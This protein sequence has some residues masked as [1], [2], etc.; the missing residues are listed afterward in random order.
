[1][2]QVESFGLDREDIQGGK[3]KKFKGKENQTDRVG[4]IYITEK[5]M[6]KGVKAHY[7]DRYFLC[8]S[9][10]E[11]KEICCLHSYEKN[12]PSYRIGCI[13]VIYDVATDK[14]GKV[15]LKGYE[16]LPWVF[17]EK[18][19]GTLSEENKEHPLTGCDLKLKC[20]NAEYQ[21]FEVHSC[22]ESIW[23]SN[24]KLKEKILEQASTLF[25]ELPRSLSSDLSITEIKELLGVDAAGSED[26][27]ADIDLGA[28]ADVA[29]E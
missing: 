29:M 19:Y 3:F 14:S 15:S 7:K 8:K 22:K 6:F 2:A 4:I 18:M 5:E 9:T 16:L 28:V 11:K 24:A 1:M 12:R 20:T 25:E 23:Q 21:N 27:A 17:G 10:K 13:L 26:A